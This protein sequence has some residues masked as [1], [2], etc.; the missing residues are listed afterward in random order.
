MDY[1]KKSLIKYLVMQAM[2]R[3]IPD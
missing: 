2:R 1:K 3:L